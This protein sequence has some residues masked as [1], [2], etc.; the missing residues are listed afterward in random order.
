[1]FS[2][3][4]TKKRLA[5]LYPKPKYNTIIEPFAGAAGY[6]LL[7]PEK[8]VILYDTNPKIYKIW[9]YLIAATKQDIINLPDIDIGQKVTDFDLSE[10]EKWL[11]G[12]CINPGSSCPKI[13]ASKRCKWDAYKKNIAIMVEKIKHWK[14]YNDSYEKIPNQEATWHIDPPYQKAGKYYFGYNK[15]NYT[16]LA[17]WSKERFGQVMVCENEGADYLPFQFLTEHMGSMQ[18]NTEV[19][20]YNE[21]LWG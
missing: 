9:E 10:P 4:G 18:K 12:F 1:M 17:G 20:W 8:N 7:Y 6:S 15:M 16:K 3:Y 13:T 11:I 14:I 21:R 5:P 2:Y 19:V